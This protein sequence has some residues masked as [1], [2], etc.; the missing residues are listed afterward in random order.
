[1]ASGPITLWQIKGEKVE[2]VIDFLF[3][4]STITVDCYCVYAIK[5]HLLFGRK[6]MTIL[7]IILKNRDITLPTKICI[8]KVITFP[9]VMYRCEKW[10][11][12]KAEC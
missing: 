10:A 7:D 12:K 5:R 11:I 2:A 8:I 3:L 1:M 6:T 9:V 4:G